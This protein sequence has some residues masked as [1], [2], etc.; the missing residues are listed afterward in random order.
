VDQGRETLWTTCGWRHVAAGREEIRIARDAPDQLFPVK[1]IA[2]S[3]ARKG[4]VRILVPAARRVVS[5]AR[6]ASR[7]KV[8]V[9]SDPAGFIAVLRQDRTSPPSDWPRGKFQP[10]A[11]L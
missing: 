8:R 1:S 9:I 5:V 11:L 7:V 3:H 4:G 10:R 2:W 6:V